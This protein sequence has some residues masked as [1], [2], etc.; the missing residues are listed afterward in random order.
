MFEDGKIIMLQNVIAN[1]ELSNLSTFMLLPEMASSGS[2]KCSSCLL[3]LFDFFFLMVFDLFSV[4][5][6]LSFFYHV[7][8]NNSIFCF[9]MFTIEK[10]IGGGYVIV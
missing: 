2:G 6:L 7:Q 8:F 3:F 4:I 1:L 10:K 5:S 9:Y